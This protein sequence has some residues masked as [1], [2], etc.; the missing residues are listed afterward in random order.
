MSA[1]VLLHPTVLSCPALVER[2]ERE[3]GRRGYWVDG[4]KAELQ[5]VEDIEFSDYTGDMDFGGNAA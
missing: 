4:R 5:Q 1:Q 3:T 2:I